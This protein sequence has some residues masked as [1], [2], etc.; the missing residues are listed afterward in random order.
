MC[1]RSRGWSI[2]T[3]ELVCGDSLSEWAD[4]L[5]DSNVSGNDMNTIDLGFTVGA[6]LY[7]KSDNRV[8]SFFQQKG[9]SAFGSRQY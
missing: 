5:Q 9:V 8:N 3:A 1:G 4:P 7:I 2:H 6:T